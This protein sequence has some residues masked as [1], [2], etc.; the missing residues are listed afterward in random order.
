MNSQKNG[1]TRCFIIRAHDFEQITE[2][3]CSV[4]F[5]FSDREKT[6]LR[7][8]QDTFLSIMLTIGAMVL[9]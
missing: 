5:W 3:V 8:T 1:E 7:T 6:L 9:V 2:S 4:R